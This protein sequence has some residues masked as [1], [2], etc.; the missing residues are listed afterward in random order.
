M[1]KSY[2]A[3]IVCLTISVQSLAAPGPEIKYLI[4][5]PASMLD[6]GLVRLRAAASNTVTS[7]LATIGLKPPV[8]VETTY[9][10]EH[11]QIHVVLLA[12]EAVA[13]PK[14]VCR[15][16]VTTV[17]AWM[18]SSPVWAEG[19]AHSGYTTNEEQDAAVRAA[20]PGMIVID[21]KVFG[22]PA[23]SAGH[24]PQSPAL[25]SGTL[26]TSDVSFSAA[27]ESSASGQSRP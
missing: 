14:E 7:R 23:L 22:D 11:N 10:Y 3:A 2:A 8:I 19:F 27:P 16:L 25:C 12:A 18:N 20:L 15:R 6:V 26:R 24:T 1:S 17:Q 5:E 21:A 13:D 4:H 9:N